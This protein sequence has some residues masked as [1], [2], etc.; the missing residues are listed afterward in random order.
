MLMTPEQNM[1]KHINSP[2][3]MIANRIGKPLSWYNEFDLLGANN[4][5][6]FED[7]DSSLMIPKKK[8]IDYKGSLV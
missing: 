4:E 8:L 5:P 6:S 1:K 7:V 3:L 2:N